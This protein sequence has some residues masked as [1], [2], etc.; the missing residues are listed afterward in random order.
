MLVQILPAALIAV[1]VVLVMPLWPWSRGWGWIPAGILGM[2][3]AT[4]LLFQF[5]AIEPL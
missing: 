5:I 1:L 4:L 3:M 2:G